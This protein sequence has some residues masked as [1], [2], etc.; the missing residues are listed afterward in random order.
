L[1]RDASLRHALELPRQVIETVVQGR[2]AFIEVLV[3]STVAICSASLPHASFGHFG[4]HAGTVQCL[5]TG[6]LNC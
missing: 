4:E 3:V 2:Q 5:E 1:L 6:T